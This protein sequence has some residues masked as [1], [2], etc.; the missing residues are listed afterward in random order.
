[1]A[2]VLLRRALQER[3]A[4]ASVRSAGFL[5]SGEPA[6]AASV[7]TMGKRGLDLSGHRSRQVTPGLLATA[8]LVLAMERRHVEAAVLSAPSC[9]PRCHTLKDLVREGRAYGPRRS[10]QPVHDW[11]GAV[12]GRRRREDLLVGASR[13]HDVDD[14]IG[15]NGRAFRAAAHELELLVTELAGLLFPSAAGPSEPQVRPRRWRPRS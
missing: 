1:M 12:A 6:A 7:R 14:P 9:W 13:E 11:L 3:G 4:D 5:A 10:G 2:E 15:R 8:D